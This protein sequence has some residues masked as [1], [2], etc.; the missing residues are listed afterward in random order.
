M[1][2]HTDK[3]ETGNHLSFMGF[4]FVQKADVKTGSHFFAEKKI[5]QLFPLNKEKYYNNYL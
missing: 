5:K 1:C 4:S 3:A 2:K